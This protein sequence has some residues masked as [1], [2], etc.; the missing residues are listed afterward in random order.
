MRGHGPGPPPPFPLVRGERVY[1][2]AVRMNLAAK[3]KKERAKFLAIAARL[4]RAKDGSERARLKAA[5][6]RL[7]FGE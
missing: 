2:D 3:R 1:D 4:T 5:L 7:T 6:A